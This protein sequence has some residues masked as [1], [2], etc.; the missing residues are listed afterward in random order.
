MALNVVAQFAIATL[1]PPIVAILFYLLQEKTRFG[2]RSYV[3]QQIVIGVVFG[4]IAVF[5]T[6]FGIDYSGATMNVRDA[7]PM[8]AGLLFGG[9]AGIIAGLIGGI[10]RWFAALWGRGMFTRLGC[11]IATVATGVYAALVKKY[12]YDNKRPSW[13]FALFFGVT[14]EVL[15]LLLIFITNM[16][17]T[18]QAVVVVQACTAPMLICNGLSVALATLIVALLSGKRLRPVLPQ[19]RDISTIMQ[20]G[21]L[22]VTVG[23]F[24]V[25]TFFTNILETNVTEVQ[26]KELLGISSM[27]ISGNVANITYRIKDESDVDGLL[28]DVARN[29]HVGETGFVIVA[30]GAG[31]IVSTINGGTNKTLAST[32]LGYWIERHNPEDVFK[33]T[34]E[35]EEV[36]CLY[37]E[38]AGY[39]VIAMLPVKEARFQR[40]ATVLL[41][42]YREVLLIA[43][44]Y[45]AIFFMIKYLIV[46]NIQHVNGKLAQITDGDLDVTVDVYSNS[47]FA[48][49]SDDINE[50]VDALRLSIE[51]AEHRNAAE[52]EYARTIQ[53]GALPRVFPPFPSHDDFDIYA[54]M[55]AAR[56]VGGDFYDF[57]LLDDDHLAF[58]IADVSGK[59]IPAAM[60]MM[61]A[62]TLIKSL[63][64]GGYPL[65]EVLTQANEQLCLSNEAE[66]FVTVWFG[67]IDLTSGVVTFVNAGHNPPVIMR[68]NSCIYHVVRPNMVLAGMPGIRYRTHEL[69]LEPGDAIFLYTDGVT[70]ATNIGNELFGEDRLINC[71]TKHSYDSVEDLC[72]VVHTAVDEFVGEAPQFDDIT[73]LALRFH[74]RTGD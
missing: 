19:E 61:T 60:F 23:F 52:L 12:M 47:E 67:V 11:S 55:N 69:T 58:L 73:M 46:D 3:E 26:T 28:A 54:T 38:V 36:Y 22:M 37:S 50:M 39:K 53:R 5:N 14:A 72:K 40:D 68:D 57:Y 65:E 62:K 59:G 17:R 33:A 31:D 15:H 41:S 27:G 6:E 8:T 7:A 18:T 48:S 56:E 20:T 64:E 63:A 21:L 1:L 43:A 35:G 66:M 16:D 51:A 13:L 29:W 34:Y 24:G 25:A 4:L 42:A 30:N 2:A 45:V 44:L 70:E 10:E 74:G 49:L 71:L 32:G 9:P